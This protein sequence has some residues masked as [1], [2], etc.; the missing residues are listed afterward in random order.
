[1]MKRAISVAALLAVLATPAVAAE[2]V[3]VESLLAQDYVVVGTMAS[4]IGP[5]LFLQEKQKLYL[6]FVSETPQSV[7][8]TTRYC[9]P[10][11]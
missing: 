8:V 2:S 4:P 3:T 5:G 11:K 6:C 7:A 10:V 9:K 1:M